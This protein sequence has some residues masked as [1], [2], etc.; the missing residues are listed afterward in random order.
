MV[1]DIIAEAGT[2]LGSALVA[3][4]A[5]FVA[6]RRGTDEPFKPEKVLVTVTAAFIVAVFLYGTGQVTNQEDAV[7]QLTLFVGPVAVWLQ[8]FVDRL[9]SREFGSNA[10]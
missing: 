4:L 5:Y 1:E 6:K 8:G 2:V 3:S 9:Q 10:Q 7:A